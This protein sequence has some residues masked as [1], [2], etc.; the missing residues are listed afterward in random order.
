M[1]GLADQPTISGA[2][3]S[4]LVWQTN[5]PLH[6]AAGPESQ[7]PRESSGAA[8]S[9]ACAQ[10]QGVPASLSLC[11]RAHQS[12]KKPEP[13]QVCSGTR[14]FLAQPSSHEG[15][16]ATG[17]AC[18]SASR[19]LAEAQVAPPPPCAQPLTLMQLPRRH[20]AHQRHAQL[21]L[22]L[23]RLRAAATSAAAFLAAAHPAAA[24]SAA[25]YLWQPSPHQP[26]AQPPSLAQLPP[27]QSTR[28]RHAPLQPSEQP[29]HAAALSAAASPSSTSRGGTLR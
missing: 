6:H 8:L 20:P 3:R 18:H 28:L 19:A 4:W 1:V 22:L 17:I 5:Q 14:P 26:N 11:P 25:T 2:A 23:S 16:R 12:R 15:H 21:P 7:S 27:Q 10:P 13:W 24:P 9:E 29:I